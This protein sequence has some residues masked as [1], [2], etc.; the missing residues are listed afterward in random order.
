MFC[1]CFLNTTYFSRSHLQISA[2]LSPVVSF[3][4]CVTLAECSNT[5]LSFLFYRISD[6]FCILILSAV[7]WKTVVG[8]YASIST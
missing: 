7:S 6:F 3:F 5:E 1:L 8:Y 4:C 2:Q